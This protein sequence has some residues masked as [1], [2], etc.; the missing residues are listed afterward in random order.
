M[1]ESLSSKEFIVFLFHY[2]ADTMTKTRLRRVYWDL[3]FQSMPMTVCAGIVVAGREARRTGN[4]A[5]VESLQPD[6]Q[7]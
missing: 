5:E 1:H 7:V 6:P 4:G 3:Q 2:C